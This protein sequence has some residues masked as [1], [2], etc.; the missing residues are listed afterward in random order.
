MTARATIQTAD[1]ETIA[2]A[3]VVYT[4]TSSGP[5]IEHDDGAIT[6]AGTDYSEALREVLEERL[7]KEEDAEPDQGSFNGALEAAVS[8]SM[9]D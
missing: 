7:Q 9:P 2:E 4:S 6:L 1:G 5:L 8:G 3:T